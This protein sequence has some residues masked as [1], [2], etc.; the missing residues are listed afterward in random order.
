MRNCIKKVENQWPIHSQLVSKERKCSSCVD[1]RCLS[2]CLK[3]MKY[4]IRVAYIIKVLNIKEY[5]FLHSH[6]L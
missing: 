3:L 1:S 5:G 4:R 2:L 6:I